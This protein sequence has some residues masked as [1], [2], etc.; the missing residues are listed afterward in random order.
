M[1]DARRE[2]TR[3]SIIKAA[4]KII[5]EQGFEQA[6]ISEISEEA[7]VA[8]GVI[9]SRNMFINKLDLL[10]SIVLDFWKDLNEKIHRE[11]DQLQNPE[12]KLRKVFSIIGVWLQG[13]EYS[14]YRFKVAQEALPYI[15]FVKEKDPELIKKRED[16]TDENRTLLTELDRIIEEGQSEGVFDK[17]LDPSVMRQ[18][19][20]GAFG[21]LMHGL[22]LKKSG[23]KEEIKYGEDDILKA[24]K[25]LLEKFVKVSKQQ[26]NHKFHDQFGQNQTINSSPP[27]A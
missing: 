15:Y 14:A 17:S 16:I 10:L 13:D 18:V 2:S 9:Y 7:G 20:F 25:L 12:E 4:V 27:P 22:F 21:L 24:M 1:N 23:K 3:E 8:A 6:K 5:A 11:V 19:L 26:I